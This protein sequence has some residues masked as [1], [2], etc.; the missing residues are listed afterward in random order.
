[1]ISKMSTKV[2]FVLATHNYIASTVMLEQDTYTEF[3]TALV[4]PHYGPVATTQNDTLKYLTMGIMRVIS[5]PDSITIPVKDR[6]AG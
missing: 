2:C 6:S 1:M 4:C 5:S 3:Q